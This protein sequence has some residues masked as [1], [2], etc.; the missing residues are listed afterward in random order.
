M[1]VGTVVARR[2]NGDLFVTFPVAPKD[3]AALLVDLLSLQGKQYELADV[4]SSADQYFLED[5]SA[6]RLHFRAVRE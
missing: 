3:A 4:A 5:L 2:E 1:A 6:V